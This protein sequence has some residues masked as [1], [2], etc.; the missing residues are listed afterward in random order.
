[1]EVSVTLME[2][3]VAATH[4]SAALDPFSNSEQKE[5]F[6]VLHSGILSQR[7]ER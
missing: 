5:P 7:Q 3:S 4:T 2:V 1:M 6:S